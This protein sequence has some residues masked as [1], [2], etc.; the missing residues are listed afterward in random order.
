MCA[1]LL[2]A[3]FVWAS[4]AKLI[5]HRATPAAFASLGVPAAGPAAVAVPV[6]ELGV[7][8]LLVARPDVGAALA[9]ALLALFTLVVVRGVLA[10]S[11]A[12]CA[13]FGAHRVEPVGP[14][15]VIRNGL[16][17]AIAAVAT[18]TAR[19][20]RPGAVAVAAVAAGLVAAGAL[21]RIAQRRLAS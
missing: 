14:A 3:V 1:C 17:A 7:A 9:L 21:W 6:A 19:L 20:V 15:D 16:L 18:G 11:P 10:G 13:C 2:A 8:S 4:A 12:G 5:D